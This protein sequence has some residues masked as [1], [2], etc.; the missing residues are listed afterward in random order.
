M[1]FSAVSSSSL[2]V[3]PGRALER[4]ILRQRA[5]ILPA[6]AIASTCADVLRMIIPRYISHSLLF[7]AAQ[8][9][10]YPLDSL[11]DL[12]RGLPAVHPVEDATFVVIVDQGLG[13]LAVLR[14]AVLDHLWLVVVAD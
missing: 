10:D 4:S 12:I 8:R 7:L 5:W 3:T 6:S 11:L 1:N 14:E 13:L 9:L 2:V